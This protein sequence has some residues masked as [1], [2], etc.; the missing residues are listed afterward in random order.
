VHELLDLSR[1]QKRKITLERVTVDLGKAVSRAVE[2][3]NHAISDKQH[4]ITLHLPA[5][6]PLCIEGDPTRIEQ[7]LVNLIINAAKYTRVGGAIEINL[8]REGKRA[9][10]RIR[11]NGI[12]IARDDLRR[13]F[14]LFTQ[15]EQSLER[16]Q[17]GLGLGLKLVKELVELHGGSVEATSEGIGKGSE[18]IVRLPAIAAAEPALTSDLRTRAAARSPKRILVV[19]DLADN[20]DTMEM[21]LTMHGHTVEL[22]EDGEQA[23][24][25]IL[26]GQFDIAFIDIG[27]P[28]LTGY[29]VAEQIRQ[30]AEGHRVVLIALSGYGRPEDKQK[31]TEAGFDDH[32][33][34]PVKSGTIQEL[35]NNLGR[36]KPSSA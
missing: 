14:D 7:V 3:C 31:A 27:L 17:G 12:G 10:V 22:A 5:G 2:T 24:E 15:V 29:E 13:V 6:N 11:D 21:L 23:L 4:A 16:S 20:R 18:F 35:L 34:K 1:I 36:F 8:A 33:T 30:Q 9:V 26:H 32:L 28:K 25:K 19:D